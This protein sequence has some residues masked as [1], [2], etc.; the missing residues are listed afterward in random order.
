[1]IITIDGPSGTGKTT[2]ARTLAERL[3]FVYF[4]TGAMYRAL[5]WCVLEHAID[6]HDDIAMNQLLENFSF[7]IQETEGQ[8]KYFVGDKDVTNVIRSEPVT[9]HVSAVAALKIVRDAL[10]KIQHRFAQGR[11]VVFEGRDL[12]TVVFR[13]AELKI[14]LTADP[15][16]RAQRR[17]LELLEKQPG[18]KNYDK[19]TVL[20]DLQRR[21]A[22]D[23]N[24]AVA[25]LKC[26]PDAYS[27]DTSVFSIEQVVD[28]IASYVCKERMDKCRRSSRKDTQD[29]SKK[30]GWFYRFVLFLAKCFYKLFYHHKVYGGSHFCEGGAIIAANHVSHLDPPA[31]AI[32]SPE[33]I[34]FLAK[35]GLFKPF[36]FGSVI[37][38]LNAHPVT[39]GAGNVAVFKIIG[40]LLNEGKKVLLFPEGKRAEK[41]ELGPLKSGIALL[42]SRSKAAVIP[43]YVHGT[44]S[45]WNRKRAFPKLCGKTA[46]VFGSPIRWSEWEHLDKREAQEKFTARLAQAI[47][48]LKQWYENGAKGTPP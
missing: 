45:I 44:F 14:F 20:A 36:L 21:D 31:L 7:N 27:I 9:S 18:S 25:P 13:N 47:Q 15:E 3:G 37:R 38:A 34:H 46:C 8:K 43:A 6:I 5:T 42:V 48:Q 33:E 1:M 12:G 23:M 40:T 19:Q 4:D 26:P 32:S 10:L 28:Q 35:E 16:I 11:N 41:E 39:G 30:G 22:L 29:I 24:R 17:F 2:V